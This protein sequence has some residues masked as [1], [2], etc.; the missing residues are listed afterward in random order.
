MSKHI[1]KWEMEKISIIFFY[2]K[3]QASLNT[4]KLISKISD[5]KSRHAQ[6]LFL[7]SYVKHRSTTSDL[8][9][10]KLR[11]LYFQVHFYG[12]AFDLNLT[13]Y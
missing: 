12:I 9:L 3:L 4:A 7:R 13:S 5:V 1:R 10:L 11:S 2:G 8:Y 6:T